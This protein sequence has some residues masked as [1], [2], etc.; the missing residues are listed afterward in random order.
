MLPFDITNL[1][2]GYLLTPKFTWSKFAYG[3][4]G[5]N[6]QVEKLDQTQLYNLC[7][8]PCAYKLLAKHIVYLSSIPLFPESNL[9][10]HPAKGLATNTGEPIKL[11]KKLTNWREKYKLLTYTK[12]TIFT[13]SI[14]NPMASEL[15][16][17]ILMHDSEF[18]INLILIPEDHTM[19]RYR[20]FK[21]LAKASCANFILSGRLDD[22]ID[23]YLDCEYYL[24][25]NPSDEILDKYVPIY[26]KDEI[27]TIGHLLRNPNSRAI[28]LARKSSYSKWF[29]YPFNYLELN[30]S[31]SEEIYVIIYGL[32]S[33]PS[34]YAQVLLEKIL[35][36]S[37]Y[38][39]VLLCA[40]MDNCNFTN[41]SESII[42]KIAQLVGSES[43]TCPQNLSYK[44]S[45]I[46]YDF[47]RNPSVKAIEFIH[48]IKP[49]YLFEKMHVLAK[50]PAFIQFVESY[51]EYYPELITRPELYA[52]PGLFS[53]IP[54][55]SVT[56]KI[57]SL[58]Y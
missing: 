43:D 37:C 44:I 42:N 7:A 17:D 50:N 15:L 41:V 35:D 45:S 2:V 51:P 54:T 9:S 38:N 34:T 6:R 57:Q 10:T 56:K 3:I 14:T 33:N 27:R 31:A 36:N 32:S 21:I 46:F 49:S 39:H 52:N 16:D 19:R 12:E 53:Q 55:Q 5:F 26:Y 29:D 11:F 8:N 23:F 47:I 18:I 4:P 58:F 22:L 28:D 40:M 30:K 20:L 13:S 25:A 24:L 1:I 48:K